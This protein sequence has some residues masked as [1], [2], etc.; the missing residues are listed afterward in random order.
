MRSLEEIRE[1]CHITEDGHWLWRGSLRPDGRANIYAPDH[2][3]GTMQVQSGPR[4]VWQCYTGQAPPDGWRAFGTCEEKTCC[5]P[6]HMRCGN[7]EM[8]GA[9][10]AK[11]GVWKGST[12]RIIANRFSNRKRAKLTPDVI[13]YIQASPLSGLELAQELGISKTSVSKA[14]CGLTRAFSAV[15]GVFAGLGAR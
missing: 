6:E 10:I 4:A 5:N 8:L 12:A 14:R 3:S 1:R 13:A 9:Y 11:K 7:M 15:S 2:K